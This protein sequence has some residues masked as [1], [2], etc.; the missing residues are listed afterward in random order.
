MKRAIGILLV[1]TTFLFGAMLAMAQDEETEDSY[2]ADAIEQQAKTGAAGKNGIPLIFSAMLRYEAH[3][4][5]DP[6]DAA[7]RTPPGIN[8]GLNDDYFYTILSMTGQVTE[9]VLL[10]GFTGY[11]YGIE[12]DQ[13]E[14]VLFGVNYLLNYPNY[15]I[16]L[17]YSFNATDYASDRIDSDRFSLSILNIFKRPHSEKVFKLTTTLAGKTDWSESR[18]WNEKL[19]LPFIVD[20][21]GSGSVSYTYGYNLVADGQIYNQYSLVYGYALSKRTKLSAEYMHVQRTDSFLFVNTGDRF[22]PD[23][24][25]VFRLTWMQTY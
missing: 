18:T 11:R 22:Y 5:D 3:T 6:R 9:H 12:D 1:L 15:R 14:A 17:G 20:K 13:R 16:T 21:R 10:N 24:D 2:R 4:A 19:T 23:D 7:G 25:N 8:A